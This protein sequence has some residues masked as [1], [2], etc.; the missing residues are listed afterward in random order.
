M[1]PHLVDTSPAVDTSPVVATTS[2]IA[3]QKRSV[4]DD[5]I[6][7]PTIPENKKSGQKAKTLPVHMSGDQFIKYLQEKKDEKD[8]LEEQKLQCQV[9]HEEKKKEHE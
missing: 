5:I 1:P 6:V 3:C 7:Y 9:E 8:E 4:L 2:A